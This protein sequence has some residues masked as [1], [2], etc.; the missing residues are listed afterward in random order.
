MNSA[1]QRG[2]RALLRRCDNRCVPSRLKDVEQRLER[3]EEQLRLFQK[4]SRMM[5]RDMS[6]Q[7]VL[8]GIVSLVTEFM[9]CDSCLV[10]LLD[11]DR[12]VLCASNNPNSPSM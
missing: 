6:L 4:I 5:V 8:Q 2:I 12:L 11:G 3:T 10:Y 9:E 1:R 7:E